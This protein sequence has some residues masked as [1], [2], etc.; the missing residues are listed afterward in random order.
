MS[1]SISDRAEVKP[2]KRITPPR[3]L[4]APVAVTN[5]VDVVRNPEPEIGALHPQ[6]LNH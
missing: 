3:E 6:K 4:D 2:L 1:R 5:G